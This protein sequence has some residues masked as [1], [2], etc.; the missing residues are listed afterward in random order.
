M[1][2]TKSRF[3][4]LACLTYSG[5]DH[6]SRRDEARSLIAELSKRER[7]S[8][9]VCAALGDAGGVVRALEAGAS[10][11]EEYGPQGWQPLLFVAMSR[12]ADDE[13]DYVGCATAL[14]DAGAD[15]NAHWMWGG[16]YRFTAVTGAFGEGEMGPVNQPEHPEALA[17]ARLLLEHGA[18]P[19]DSQALYNR[20]F[21]QGDA[22]LELLLEFG[23]NK[24]HRNNWMV[25]D[26][27]GELRES[28]ERTLDYQLGW[29]VKHG[30]SE[31]VLLLLEAGADAT[32]ADGDVS[33]WRAAM[34][35]G[36]ADIAMSL[37]VFGAEREELDDV[38]AWAA[39]TLGGD[40][41]ESRALLANDTTLLERALERNPLLF[42]DAAKWGAV[43]AVR[44]LVGAGV[45]VDMMPQG[46]SA[47]HEAAWQNHA[48]VV[49]VL[50]AAGANPNL[51]DEHHE[52]TAAQWAMTAGN[53]EV[54]ALLEEAV[55]RESAESGSAGEAQE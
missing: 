24:D 10:A 45:D 43:D 31:R 26:A 12:V 51:R 35:R 42:V 46:T 50:L 17:L 37:E 16:Q 34:S 9:E 30:H 40:G 4:E 25:H 32:G 53:R 55:A 7:A 3:L 47:L 36:Y 5:V 19:N 38:D 8:I 48:D 14:L 20:M 39:A 13:A 11:L 21:T 6:P 18:D 52:G 49:Q 28:E 2:D 1:S 44:A 23:L 54:Q 41:D 33:L 22:C 27:S 15:A 29:A